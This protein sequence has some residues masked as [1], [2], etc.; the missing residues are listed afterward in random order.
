[1]TYK[2][3]PNLLYMLYCIQLTMRWKFLLK[4]SVC[5]LAL[6]ST[7]GFSNF[8]E[9]LWGF[10]T[11]CVSLNSGSNFIYIHTEQIYI[12]ACM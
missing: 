6:S 8:H 10:P 11:F 4:P 12:H 2:M 1:M 5:I 3:P 7:P 9:L